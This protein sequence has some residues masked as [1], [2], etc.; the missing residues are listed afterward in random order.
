[1]GNQGSELTRRVS[2]QVQAYSDA[3]RDLLSSAAP[4]QSGA[5]GAYSLFELMDREGH[6][7]MVS[8][9]SKLRASAA[10]DMTRWNGGV[11]GTM[12]F[13]MNVKGALLTLQAQASSGFFSLLKLKTY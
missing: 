12:M 6:L 3:Q 7:L 10:Q 9:F 2:L 5:D 13:T 4:K 11:P 1:M 8:K